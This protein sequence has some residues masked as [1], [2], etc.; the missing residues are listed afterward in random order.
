M[1][2]QL[3]R[4]GIFRFEKKVE[5]RSPLLW[6]VGPFV[7]RHFVPRHFVPFFRTLRPFF[8]HFVPFLKRDDVARIEREDVVKNGTF[9]TLGPF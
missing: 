5:N 1:V 7:P 2:R 3:L 9:W 8:G 4:I 6:G